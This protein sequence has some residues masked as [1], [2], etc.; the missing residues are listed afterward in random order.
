MDMEPIAGKRLGSSTRSAP[1]ENEQAETADGEHA[2]R[3]RLGD[4]V[5][6]ERGACGDCAQPA[7]IQRG[8]LAH[9]NTCLIRWDCIG[10]L[11]LRQVVGLAVRPIAKV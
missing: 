9:Y 2:D 8:H 10:I 11:H 3:S 6:I 5:R 1:L 4:Y 7:A